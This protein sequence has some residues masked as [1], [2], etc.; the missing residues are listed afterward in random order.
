MNLRSMFYYA[1]LAIALGSLGTDLI[2]TIPV[3]GNL[4][5]SLFNAVGFL[6]VAVCALFLFVTSKR[7]TAMDIIALLCIL[8]TFSEPIINLVF[9]LP[10]TNILGSIGS[11]I[12]FFIID[13]VGL[14][15]LYD[16]WK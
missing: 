16:Y 14:S 2:G 15:I 3:L 6:G 5:I 1:G 11:G 7:I 9:S 12:I 10:V 4:A 13:L 8:A